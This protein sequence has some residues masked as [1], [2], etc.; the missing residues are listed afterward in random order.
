MEAALANGG[1]VVAAS[2]LELPAEELLVR[3]PARPKTRGRKSTTAKSSG[4]APSAGRGKP[5]KPKKRRD[6]PGE[7]LAGWPAGQPLPVREYKFHP[8]RKW[9]FD[10]AWPERRVAVEL[11]GGTWS[12]GRHTRGSGY[13]KDC[14]KL[15]TA[16][17]GGWRVLRYTQT[18]LRDRLGGVCLEVQAVL[19][20]AWRCGAGNEDRAV[21][22]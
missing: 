8:I 18:D 10:L 17:R 3:A 4:A 16:V 5:K 21:A 9:R 15:N 22:G 12:G 19:G 6:L 7:F 11:D 2:G 20:L 13:Q 1:K 14:E